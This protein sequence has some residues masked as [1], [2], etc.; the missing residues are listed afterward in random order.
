MQ[1]LC[2]ETGRIGVGRR[3]FLAV[4]L[5]MLGCGVRP[6]LGAEAG[7]VLRVVASTPDLESLA[8]EVGG[9]RVTV[10]SLAKGPEDPHTVEP[11]PS[12]VREL[13]R[14]DLFLQ[15]GLGIENAWL[16]ELMGGVRNAAI[17]PGGEGNLNLGAG[18]R[19]LEGVEVEAVPGSFHEEGNPHYL[20]DPVEGL[21][22]ARAI[23]DK[24]G[25]LRPGYRAEF[26]ERYE[27]LRRRLGEWL[28]G[29]ECAGHD[30]IEALAV[31]LEGVKGA[32][33]EAFRAEHRL[34]G[35]LGALLVHRGRMVVGDHDLWPYYA[36]RCG[37]GILGYLEPSPGVPPTTRHLQELVA[38]MKERGVRVILASPYF[39]PRH[40]A[41]VSRAT[42][43]RV[44]EMAHQTGARTGAGDYL[45]MLGYNGR[46]L[47]KAME[48]E[49]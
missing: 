36:R 43:A 41:F 15:V 27:G 42:G 33:V 45:G 16:K 3:A 24:L 34:G 46:Q 13:E 19:A 35:F 23:R 37:L 14:A 47:L 30:D 28:V 4:G 20:L 7:G 10:L 2:K 29:E 12:F 5:G 40:A 39:D 38:R 22:V 31:R 48:A 11:K 6:L 18:V 49:R 25:V 26:E 32:E 8:R 1:T 21:R 44:V 17:R 9:K